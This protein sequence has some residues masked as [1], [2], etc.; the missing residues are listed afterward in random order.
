MCWN[1]IWS[2]DERWNWWHQARWNHVG[3]LVIWFTSSDAYLWPSFSGV[4]YVSDFIA[5]PLSATTLSI[6]K[7]SRS[8]KKFSVTSLE[9][10]PHKICGTA[11]TLY[12]F[13]FWLSWKIHCFIKNLVCFSWEYQNNLF[14]EVKEGNF[15]SDSN[16][17]VE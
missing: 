12:L 16:G 15:L 14:K 3:G 11:S 6:P 8:I 17:A 10:P 1:D 5:S 13:W 4:K 7:K 9:K 2:W